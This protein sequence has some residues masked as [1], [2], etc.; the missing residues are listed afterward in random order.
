MLV[1][2]AQVDKKEDPRILRTRGLLRE[3]LGSL[4]REKSFEAITVGEITE[5]ATLNRVTFYAH[6]ADK[7]ALLEYAMGTLIRE[8]LEAQLGAT[9]AL[10][11]AALQKL[12]L[13]VCNF[14]SDIEG[15]CPPPRGQMEPL[16]EKQIKQEVYTLLLGWLSAAKPRRGATLP[17]AEQAA[18]VATWAIYGA[19]FQWSQQPRPQPVADF[20]RQVLP[21]VQANLAPYIEKPVP[22]AVR[23]VA[24]GRAPSAYLS[25]ALRLQFHVI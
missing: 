19:A 21:L 22:N 12:V 5:R 1:R 9:P 24:A 2:D 15:H 25:Y 23:K 7:Y 13:V 11:E 14:L 17:T 3:A 20:V 16:M 4:L 18:M 8:Q 10:S 6:F